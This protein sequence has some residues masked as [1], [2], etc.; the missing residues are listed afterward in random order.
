VGAQ[1]SVA[2]STG[3]GEVIPYVRATYEHEFANDSREIVTELVTQPGIPM[4]TS[5]DSPDRDY[6]K[7][8]V[9]TQ[10]VFSENVSGVIGYD[11]IVGRKDVTDQSVK[12]EIRFQF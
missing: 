10:V 7:L 2:I 5:T 8:G 4:R 11:A 12:A 3:T 9:G 6:V 1:A